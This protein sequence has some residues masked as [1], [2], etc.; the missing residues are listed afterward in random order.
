MG[1]DRFSFEIYRNFGQT[2]F[3]IANINVLYHRNLLCLYYFS[4]TALYLI[5][6]MI[7]KKTIIFEW[8]FD[9]GQN[10]EMLFFFPGKNF[11]S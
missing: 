10:D 7:R 1:K 11:K 8:V 6:I 2:E 9:H 3:C 5:V 4:R